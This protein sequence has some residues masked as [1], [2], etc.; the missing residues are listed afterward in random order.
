MTATPLP[1]IPPPIILPPAVQ[2]PDAGTPLSSSA[3]AEQAEKERVV[4]RKKQEREEK[5]RQKLRD[6]GSGVATPAAAATAG[7]LRF[8]PREWSAVR[9]EKVGEGDRIRIMSWNVSAHQLV[10]AGELCIAN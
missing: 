2:S 5:K 6:Q 9:G 10:I 1:D 8:R 3:E 7:P 4:L